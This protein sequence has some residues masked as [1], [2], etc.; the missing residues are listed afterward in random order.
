VWAV[1]NFAVQP[2]PQYAVASAVLLHHSLGFIET[3]SPSVYLFELDTPLRTL[4]DAATSVA[5]E[6]VGC[7]GAVIAVVC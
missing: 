7:S 6:L 5:L 3:K 1:K 4:L 2:T